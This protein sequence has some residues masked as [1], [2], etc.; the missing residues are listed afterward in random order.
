MAFFLCEVRPVL[1]EQVSHRLASKVGEFD[2]TEDADQQQSY[3]TDLL[4]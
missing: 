1:S 4:T 3:R 2:D